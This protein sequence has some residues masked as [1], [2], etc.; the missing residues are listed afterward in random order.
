MVSWSSSS[1]GGVGDGTGGAGGGRGGS[2]C[3]RTRGAASAA[4]A[5]GRFPAARS[6][7][8]GGSGGA[9]GNGKACPVFGNRHHARELI[10]L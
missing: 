5:S 6:L 8:G 7:S 10:T 9:V 2:T 3:T 4:A 1:L